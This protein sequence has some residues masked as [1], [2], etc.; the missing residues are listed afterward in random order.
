MSK[1]NKEEE[2]IKTHVINLNEI[3]EAEKD[4]KH[5]KTKCL[6]KKFVIAG[7]FLIAVGI[8]FP[9]F[10]S[11]A[12]AETKV[13]AIKKVNKNRLTCIS[14]IQNEPNYKIYSKI[15][16]V[17]ENDRLKSSSKNVNISNITGIDYNSL[18]AVKQTLDTYYLS[19]NNITYNT[20]M[21][22]DSV[23]TSEIVN[24]YNLFD[25]NTYNE[26]LNSWIR[27]KTFDKNY[28]LN[29]IKNE[30]EKLGYLCN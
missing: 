1:K 28:N 8:I 22:K 11:L 25:K 19:T 12:S 18:N 29:T 6:P 30:S 3:R 5:F 26:T 14:N 17:F 2:L 27:I 20:Y 7:L 9:S 10:Q 24:D 21:K 13:S 15:T 23:V 4:E 16:Y